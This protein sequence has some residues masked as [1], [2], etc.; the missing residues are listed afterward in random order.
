MERPFFSA[1]YLVLLSAVVVFGTTSAA[2]HQSAPPPSAGSATAYQHGIYLVFPFENAGASPRLDWLGEGLEELTIQRLSGAGEQVY[3]HAGRLVELERY[4]LPRSSKLSRATMLHV[5]EA[6]DADF[7]V[8]GRFSVGGT[9]L[10]IESRV[11]KVSAGGLG[12]ALRGAGT[13]GS[14]LDV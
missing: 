13:M 4:G 12:Q 7:V 3:S 11:L 9:S 5:A 1:R 10:T 6:L 14:V 8:F 2:A